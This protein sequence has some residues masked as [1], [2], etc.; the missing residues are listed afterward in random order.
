MKWKRC[1]SNSARISSSFYGTSAFFPFFSICCIQ[2]DDENLSD[3]GAYSEVC[4]RD[5]SWFDAMQS[6]DIQSSDLSISS[7]LLGQTVTWK[8]V[9]LLNMT[10]SSRLLWHHAA[11]DSFLHLHEDSE[12]FVLTLSSTTGMTYI[13]SRNVISSN[14]RK[15]HFLSVQ[16]ERE[17]NKVGYSLRVRVKE[18]ECIEGATHEHGIQWF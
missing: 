12:F 16:W 9:N 8:G 13:F 7:V 6:I 3:S 10:S 5:Q 18:R 17:K 1:Q 15:I 4:R 14:K 11:R 2:L